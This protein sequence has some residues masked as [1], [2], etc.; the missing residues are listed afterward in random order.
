MSKLPKQLCEDSVA[1]NRRA[2]V[3]FSCPQQSTRPAWA[4]IDNESHGALIMNFCLGGVGLLLSKRIQPGTRLRI[5]LGRTTEKDHG[6]LPAR[7]IHATARE[8]GFWVLG[9]VFDERLSMGELRA[10][11]I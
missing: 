8:D 2:S 5:K 3:R 4:V 1:D 7:V 11:L 9:C 10:F 6:Q